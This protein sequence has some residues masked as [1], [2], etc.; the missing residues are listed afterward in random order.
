M[1][2]WPS[3]VLRLVSSVSMPRSADRGRSREDRVGPCM[4]SLEP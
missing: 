4:L 2:Q 3:F 1:V